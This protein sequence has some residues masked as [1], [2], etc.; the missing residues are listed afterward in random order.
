MT[1]HRQAEQTTILVVDDDPAVG[2][3]ARAGLVP[4]GYRVYSVTSGE[5]A[6]RHTAG[7][8]PDLILLDVILPGI[9]G[10]EVCRQLRR[11]PGTDQIPV[12]VVTSLDDSA[13]IE[14]AYEAGATAFVT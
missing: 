12:I 3:M 2:M 10:F 6:L 5:T 11:Q 14:Q 1:D 7:D 13:S 4:H 9:S 8:P